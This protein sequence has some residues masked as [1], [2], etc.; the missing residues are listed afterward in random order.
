MKAKKTSK[1]KEEKFLFLLMGFIVFF[2]V[3]AGK[4]IYNSSLK[5]KKAKSLSGQTFEKHDPQNPLIPPEEAER[6]K[7]YYVLRG[8]DELVEE[9]KII[10]KSDSLLAKGRKLALFLK[11]KPETAAL[12]SPLPQD[13]E[14]R[15]I[16]FYNNVFIL[17]FNEAFKKIF[18]MGASEEAAAVYAIVN[19]FSSLKEGTAVKF[20]VNGSEISQGE[21]FLDLSL[22]LESLPSLIKR[23]GL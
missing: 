7:V 21:G 11:E 3:L 19:S 10:R 13:L 5:E 2:L 16:F 14:L 6:I 20:L 23:T 17:D 9:E 4:L 12:Y 18:G 15:S 8:T 22:N 1:Y